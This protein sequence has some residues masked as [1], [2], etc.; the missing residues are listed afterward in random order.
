MRIVIVA[1]RDLANPQSGG[2]EVLVDTMARGALARGHE[3]V[4][5]A[6]DPV[7]Q[8]SYEVV[9][10]GST[11]GQYLGAPRKVRQRFSDWDVCVDVSN[12]LPFFSPLWWKG[13]VVQLVHHVHTDQWRLR[14]PRPLSDIGSVIERKLVPHLYRRHLFAAVSPSTQAQLEALGVPASRIRQLPNATE[15]PADIAK[16]KAAAPQFLVFGRLVPHKRVDLVLRH[17]PEIHERTGGTLLIAGDGPDR[18]ELEQMASDGVE[19]L[20]RVDDAAKAELLAQSW[21]LLH[22]A[23][24]E[25]WG[26]VVMEA[27]SYG[28]PAVGF[29]VPGVRDSIVDGATGV[30]ARD[31][32]DFVQRWLSLTEDVNER[33]RLGE[34]A[35]QR[36][37]AYGEDHTA[38]AFL[39]ICREACGFTAGT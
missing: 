7:E 38:E 18:S 3:V 35:V 29:D 39:D 6:G 2:S 9:G 21:L 36:A 34:T 12:G 28:T 14:F 19:F 33:M 4:L 23:A 24:H 30:L 15:R 8:R 26:I 11:F 5:V 13:P 32:D 22:P 17:W 10:S 27:A 20:G 16:D 37:A 25:G 31:E 1:W